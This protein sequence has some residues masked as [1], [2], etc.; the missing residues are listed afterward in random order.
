MVNVVMMSDCVSS[1]L[2][3]TTYSV[4]R[5]LGAGGFGG[6]IRSDYNR[7]GKFTDVYSLHNSKYDGTQYIVSKFR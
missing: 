1:V 2:P 5:S 4:V 7:D 6:T 3:S